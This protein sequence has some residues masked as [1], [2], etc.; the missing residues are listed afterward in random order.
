M[1]QQ[2]KSQQLFSLRLVGFGVETELAVA[3]DWL[4]EGERGEALARR[5]AIVARMFA[6]KDRLRSGC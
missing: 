5:G 6:E 4:P 1:K 3:R 2:S